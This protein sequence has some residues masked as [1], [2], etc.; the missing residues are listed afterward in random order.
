MC[1]FLKKRFLFQGLGML[2]LLYSQ[3]YAVNLPIQHWITQKQTPVYFI[4]TPRTPAILDVRIGFYAGSSKDDQTPGLAYLCNQ[5]LREGSGEYSSEQ[6]ADQ[7][8]EHAA[9]LYLEVQP[10]FGLVGL[11]TLSHE[12]V[13]EPNIQLMRT[14]ISKPQFKEEDIGRLKQQGYAALQ[15]QEQTPESLADQHVYSTLYAKTP[16]AHT[17][18]GKKSALELIDRAQLVSF[19]E[20]YYT[21]KN[22][23]IV[24]TGPISL[25]RAKIISEQLTQDLPLGAAPAAE[26]PLP[27]N[28][29]PQRTHI[30]YPSQQS[31]LR[32]ADV[33]I[34]RKSPD[35]YALKVGNYILGGSPFSSRLFKTIRDEHGL[36]Y[37]IHSYFNLLSRRG[38]FV[39]SLQTQHHR[40]EEALQLTR[41]VLNDFIQK[42]PTEEEVRSAKKGILGA[43]PLQFSSNQDTVQQLF[44]LAI[45]QLPLDY[46]EK[47]P[48]NIQ[49]VSQEQIQKAFKKHVIPEHLSTIVVGPSA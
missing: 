37:A 42:G 34:S 27:D 26:E 41:S 12:S 35:F 16:Y 32:L 28:K 11:R 8:A 38:P 3:S 49:N 9:Q 31:H 48:Q 14:L 15:Q 33:A 5:L 22:A 6:I 47:L 25:E 23:V 44:M 17:P 21:A 1:V 30:P 24:M 2:C 46:F 13:R 39:I 36:S 43:L 20:K 29:R 7:L 10:D 45:E 19:F 40:T 4:N 18:L